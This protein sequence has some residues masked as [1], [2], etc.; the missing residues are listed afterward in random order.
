MKKIGRMPYMFTPQNT[1]TLYLRIFCKNVFSKCYII[2]LMK[3]YREES[4]YIRK[5]AYWG[6]FK[7]SI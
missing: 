5:N 4:R 6:N 7:N 2:Y 3:K 1:F